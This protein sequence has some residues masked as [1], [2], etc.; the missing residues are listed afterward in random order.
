MIILYMRHSFLL[1]SWQKLPLTPP[2]GLTK[3]W[4]QALMEGIA[5]SLPRAVW[6]SP[7]S[8]QK[9]HSQEFIPR[10]EA[11]SEIFVH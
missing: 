11:Y 10:K 5:S 2:P 3:S 4:E 7:Q 9:H 8:L 1:C 6:Q